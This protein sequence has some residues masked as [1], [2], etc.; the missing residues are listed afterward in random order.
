MTVVLLIVALTASAQG[1]TKGTYNPLVGDGSLS[2]SF[3]GGKVIEKSEFKERLSFT[4]EVEEGATLS[5]SCV[6]IFP[7]ITK[8][9]KKFQ[10]S[11]PR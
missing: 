11:H 1:E 9:L 3:S 7:T 6:F 2:Y 5:F 10:V 4:Y 8:R